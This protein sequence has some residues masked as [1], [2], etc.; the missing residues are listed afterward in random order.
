MLLNDGDIKYV[1][2]VAR[3]ADARNRA[4][5]ELMTSTCPECQRTMTGLDNDD[6]LV[7]RV[8]GAE[9]DDAQVFVVIGCEGYWVINPNVVG[10]KCDTWLDWRDEPVFG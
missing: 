10:I 2:A 5:W 3:T 9:H 8:P 1:V 6:H 4:V 7:L